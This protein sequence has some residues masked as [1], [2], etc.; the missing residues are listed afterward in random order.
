MV[1]LTNRV[2]SE[3]GGVHDISQL[4]HQPGKSNNEENP[5]SRV[6]GGNDPVLVSGEGLLSQL[7]PSNDEKPLQFR[8]FQGQT[9]NLF[10]LRS[11]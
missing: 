11:S 8:F 6:Q 5:F 4:V 10:L 7:D 2:S 9:R 3:V 1:S